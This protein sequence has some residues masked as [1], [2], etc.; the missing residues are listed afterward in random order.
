MIHVCKPGAALSTVAICQS[1]RHDAHVF[2]SE[3]FLPYYEQHW[4]H[5]NEFSWIHYSLYLQAVNSPGYGAGFLGY[6]D[7]PALP[8]HRTMSSE[9]SITTQL[10][11]HRKL[12]LWVIPFI[13][14]YFN[15]VTV[16]EEL[17]LQDQAPNFYL[18]VMKRWP[19]TKLRASLGL[20]GAQQQQ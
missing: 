12:L 6:N 9:T 13:I 10:Q 16:W 20:I 5:T 2:W 14:Y 19:K 4:R 8:S 18:C 15:N 17:F 7:V 11:V 3:Q 1:R